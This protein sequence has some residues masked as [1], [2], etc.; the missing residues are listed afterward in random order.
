MANAMYGHG[1]ENMLKGDIHFDTDD[2]RVKS[3]DEG[4]HTVDLNADEDVADLAA[5]S[6]EFAS[7]ALQ[8]TTVALGTADADDLSPAFATATGDQ[9]ESIIVY[10]HSG[11]E[12]GD[13]LIVNIDTA[14][15]LPLTPD[16]NNIDITWSS[17]SDKI[18]TL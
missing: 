11:A 14:T 16:G 9:F 6:D 7:G 8:T 4:D 10:V 15:G 12:S 17:G 5:N 18:F 1:R 13:F 3:L 2:I